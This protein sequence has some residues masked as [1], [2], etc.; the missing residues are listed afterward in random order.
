MPA[1]SVTPK[2]EVPRGPQREDSESEVEETK[3]DSATQD[4]SARHISSMKLMAM[5]RMKF[6][7][8]AY[9]VH[10]M[11]NCFYIKAPRKLS[12]VSNLHL[13]CKKGSHKQQSEIAACRQ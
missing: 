5:L 2:I 8:G 4:I 10:M 11:Q 7:I 6:G 12:K 13:S 3:R 9:D 1:A